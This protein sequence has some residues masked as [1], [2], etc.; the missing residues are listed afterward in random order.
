MKKTKILASLC[1]CA[2]LFA[3]CVPV[4]DDLLQGNSAIDATAFLTVH[5]NQTNDGAN[6]LTSFCNDFETFLNEDH[7]YGNIS[8]ALQISTQEVVQQKTPTTFSLDATTLQIEYA[9][10]N[11]VDPQEYLLALQQS[12][13]T[14]VTYY[15][16]SL[17]N[18]TDIANCAYKLI[19]QNTNNTTT[20]QQ[21]QDYVDQNA[22]KQTANATFCN[23]QG[24]ALNEHIID[25]TNKEESGFQNC[26][27]QNYSSIVV[28][29]KSTSNLKN[30][31]FGVY[32]D[33]DTTIEI[34]FTFVN[35]NQNTNITE[36]HTL[37][38]AANTFTSKD[39]KNWKADFD[40]PISPINTQFDNGV[41]ANNNTFA[42]KN[43]GGENSLA[44]YYTQE[45]NQLKL[46]QTLLNN[47][48]ADG[49]MEITFNNSSNKPFCF[50]F[51]SVL[52]A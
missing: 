39:L 6:L 23:K 40:M 30:L 17:Q 35:L 52:Q 36:S 21:V 16:L 29:P 8:L 45:N 11:N 9:T 48:F 43:E 38:I 28:N 42:Q 13:Q 26:V 5:K 49:Y 32:S 31:I 20:K 7:N 41:F 15:G 46:N 1:L 47:T 24:L 10:I 50:A 51:S 37:Q 44:Q 4:G 3:G 19:L 14:D 34:T 2:A 25:F 12:Y 33:V 22:P 18:Q 27:A